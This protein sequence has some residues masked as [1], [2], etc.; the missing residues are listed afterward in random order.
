MD[1]TTTNAILAA[2]AAPKEESVLVR[3]HN[4]HTFLPIER[5]A[6]L[7][8]GDA[9]VMD[10]GYSTSTA[11]SLQA[12][13][14]HVENRSVQKAAASVLKGLTSAA[15]AC[16]E[17][18][19]FAAVMNGSYAEA[20]SPSLVGRV[21]YGFKSVARRLQNIAV[22]LFMT[23]TGYKIYED[24]KWALLSEKDF[25]KKIQFST[26]DE[27]A[28]KHADK[29]LRKD[30]AYDYFKGKISD[31]LKKV[32]KEHGLKGHLSDE[33]NKH[34]D[35]ELKKVLNGEDLEFIKD[36]YVWTQ[37][38]DKTDDIVEAFGLYIR[39]ML[40]RQSLRQEIERVFGKEGA[41]VVEKIRK[42]VGGGPNLY[43]QVMSIC[44]QRLVLD[45][46]NF[47]LGGAVMSMIALS[48]ST[49]LAFPL[50]MHVSEGSTSFQYMCFVIK[51]LVL[52][53]ILF[54]PHGL[55][56]LTIFNLGMLINTIAKGGIS[57]LPFM[58]SKELDN[59]T[60]LD[61]VLIHLNVILVLFSI[62]SIGCM[63][64]Y[65]GLPSSG[66]AA[67][68]SAQLPALGF[69]IFA[70]S[71]IWSDS[72]KK[73]KMEELEKE[74]LGREALVGEDG[75]ESFMEGLFEKYG[76]DL[77]EQVCKKENVF[78]H[79]RKQIP[80]DP[81][82]IFE[83]SSEEDLLAHVLKHFKSWDDERKR[84]K[85][86]DDQQHLRA[87]MDANL[88]QMPD[89]FASDKTPEYARNLYDNSDAISVDYPT[90]GDFE[91]GDDDFLRSV[92]RRS[93]NI[94]TFYSPYSSLGEDEDNI[95]DRLPGNEDRDLS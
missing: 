44:R 8:F 66:V 30:L 83:N 42:T 15:N 77:F 11:R 69:H 73:R 38:K 58:N 39:V 71:Q 78:K 81:D 53:S 52:G 24:A 74:L 64:S 68:A 28:E 46:L 91:S 48:V 55:V 22:V 85:L 36:R 25:N 32:K 21:S 51:A 75:D 10:A 95:Y 90:E 29:K 35:D 41:S 60:R 54:T 72:A 16:A 49:A 33:I 45:T 23:A 82:K 19:N 61:K 87:L 37:C 20:S 92:G 50:L 34:L 31:F 26:V 27:V 86:Q 13:I 57:K 9:P 76:Y 94:V 47:I 18:L 7:A 5:A 43:K 63:G 62:F 59:C 67:T 40:E 6:A 1:I 3:E 65:G 17:P 93:D 88:I 4:E 14:D 79:I 12:T 56:T 2:T 80:D 89:F 70:I 84:E